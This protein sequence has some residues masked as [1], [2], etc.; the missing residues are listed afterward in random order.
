M[1]EFMFPRVL[2]DRETLERLDRWLESSAAN[3]AAKRYVREA[4]D[5]IARALAAREADA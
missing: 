5:D 2:T 3:P 1:L 4:R